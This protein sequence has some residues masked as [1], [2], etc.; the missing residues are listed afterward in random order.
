MARTLLILLRFGA[1]ETGAADGAADGADEAGSLV[2]IA[3]VRRARGLQA[4]NRHTAVCKARHG[5]G[6]RRT[7]IIPLV[8]A[9]PG[10]GWFS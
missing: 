3:R 8:V 4:H 2:L 10:T 6:S 9:V 1:V 7:R 5:V